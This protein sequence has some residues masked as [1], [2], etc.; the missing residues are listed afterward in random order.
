MDGVTDHAFRDVITSMNPGGVSVCVSEFVRVTAHPL[1]AKVIERAC[2]EILHGGATR[3]GI[4]VLVQLLG[5]EPGPMAE[6]A[7]TAMQAGAWGIDLNFGCPAKCVNR[8]EGGAALLKTPKRIEQVVAAV[9]RVVPLD[10]PVS[11]KVRLGWQANDEI[12]EIARAAERGG[13]TWLTVHGRTKL[14]M[15]KPP[16]DWEAIGR[17]RRS[18]G[19]PVIANGDL[20]SV[21]DFARCETESGCTGFMV[22]RGSMGRPWI[23]RA[24]HDGASDRATRPALREALGRYLDVLEEHAASVELRL[25]RVKQWLALGAKA[26]AVALPV[27]EA[28][29]RTRTV[30]DLRA[31]LKSSLD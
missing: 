24:L 14:A 9:R 7:R 10:R 16:A 15:Y 12:G 4:P 8:H 1:P 25:V 18:V 20:N 21:E 13:A 28:V 19:I 17:A 23:F 3:S 5:G 2:P 22:G 26:N 29:K 30:D 11:V 31:A 27:F 6:T